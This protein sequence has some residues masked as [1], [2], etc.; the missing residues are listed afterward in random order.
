[1]GGNSLHPYDYSL[2]HMNIRENARRR[3]QA[4]LT[5]MASGTAG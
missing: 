4:Y 2:F 1:M 3:V 5:V